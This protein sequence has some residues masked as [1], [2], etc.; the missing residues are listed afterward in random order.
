MMTGCCSNA[1]GCCGKS[2]K[3]CC[4]PKEFGVQLYSV[5]ELIG[6]STKYADNHVQVLAKL[7][8]LGYS[9]VEAANYNNGKF[10]GVSP[11][12]FKADV[13]A[14]GLKVLSSHSYKNLTNEEYE[15]G[16]FSESLAWW[17]GCIA[18]HKAAGMKYI[19]APSARVPESKA[20]LKVFCDYLNAIGKKCNEA[21]IKFG[22]HNHS[23]EF[24]Q[25][26]DV[27]MYDY[28]LEN[29]DPEAVF[30][31]MDVFWAVWGKV[32]P[33]EYFQKY[34][35]RFSCLHIKDHREVGQSGMVGFDAIFRNAE[36]G[37]CQDYIVEM[38]GSSFGDIMKTCEVSINYL[39]HK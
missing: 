39:L 12:Q 18:A 1:D 21:G 24:R 28:M 36:L 35:E 17:D 9:S 15:S 5:R 32:A 6:D 29:T 7:A 38:E 3:C 25:I 2:D 8:E 30:F 13:E 26:E 37:G 16:D 11:E 4:G 22:Y 19:V 27:V 20:G 34:P 10:Y 31:Q 23:Q 33:V 14:A